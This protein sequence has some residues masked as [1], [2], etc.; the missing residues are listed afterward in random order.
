MV[1]PCFL[2]RRGRCLKI[3]NPVTSR[4]P[5]PTHNYTRINIGDVG[6]IR[7]G[8]FHLLFSAV[9]PLGERQLGDDVPA[10]FEELAVRTPVSGQPRLP[11]CLRTD[12][13]R[14]IG[15]G[16]SATVSS[17]LYVLPTGHLPFVLKCATQGNWRE[18]L[19]RAHWELWCSTSDEVPDVSRRFSGGI[20]V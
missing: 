10:T 6:F 3:Q 5:A 1:T 15:V 18:F 17:T 19:I 20:R 12:T 13:V 9:S 2:D 11:C 4:E 14:E 16:L 7:R 8:Q